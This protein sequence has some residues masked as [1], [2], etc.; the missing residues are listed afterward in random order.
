MALGVSV[1]LLLGCV[2]GWGQQFSQSDTI[3]TDPFFGWYEYRVRM[4]L[5]QTFVN[6]ASC[7]QEST[8]R[9]HVPDSKSAHP[10][11][12][13]DTLGRMLSTTVTL[14]SGKTKTMV[15][16]MQ[17]GNTQVTSYQVSG[18]MTMEDDPA[19]YLVEL[20]PAQKVPLSLD[21]ELG[22]GSAWLDLTDMDVKALK[23][24]SGQANVFISY[25]HP[26]SEPMHLIAVNGGMGR[27]V[28]RN[29][30]FARAE[31]VRIENGMGDTKIIIGDDVRSPSQVHINVGAGTCKM[32][33]DVNAPIKLIINDNMFSAVEVPDNFVKTGDNVY[34]NLA[35]KKE[36]RKAMTMVVDPGIGK[37]TLITVDR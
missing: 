26:N 35:Y 22:I 1:S 2:N 14:A 6:A 3:D 11:V 34:V 17:R 33:A 36:S 25:K 31:K 5:G 24:R 9:F 30:E 28:V 4:P 8:V 29:L 7:Q 13:R 10:L 32:L 16:S 37:F 20:K 15:A 21:M 19:K 12:F 27:I 23:V 18:T